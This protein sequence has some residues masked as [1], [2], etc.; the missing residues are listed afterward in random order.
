MLLPSNIDSN[1]NSMIFVDNEQI[2][3]LPSSLAIKI[4][5]EIFKYLE[6]LD[7][8]QAKLVC[9][10]WKK[11][12]N[13]VHFIEKYNIKLKT[14]A[15]VKQ[16]AGNL[17][18]PKKL[19]KKQ[20]FFLIIVRLSKDYIK[21]NVAAANALMILK[22]TKF[23]FVGSDFRGIQATGVRLA[24]TI[25]DKVNFSG[26]NLEGA[27][28]TGCSLEDAILD[29]AE[30]RD[31]QFGQLPYLNHQDDV[32]A[33][34]VSPDGNYLASIDRENFYVW[35]LE[36]FKAKK[37]TLKIKT[38]L[39][40]DTEQF[41]LQFFHNGQ[42]FLR[43]SSFEEKIE[44]W[45]TESLEMVN[46]LTIDNVTFISL[47][48]LTQD[49]KTLITISI[50]DDEEFSNEKTEICLWQINFNE[51][52]LPQIT[53]VKTKIIRGLA[54]K[55]SYAPK[56]SII[57]IHI[58]DCIEFYSLPNL[59]IKRDWTF[60]PLKGEEKYEVSDMIFTPQES[61]LMINI[62]TKTNVM[63]AEFKN[64]FKSK[65]YRWNMKNKKKG[66]YFLKKIV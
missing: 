37:Q 8:G 60:L 50:K 3:S 55:A 16:E 61:Q 17:S 31:I 9:R 40:S 34:T 62:F 4:G 63:P 19:K 66:N 52:S 57:A 49:E 25:L 58:E 29:G 39:Y 26:A 13:K 53:K 48:T 35:N 42:F 56:T 41:F 27:D 22:K 65:V 21:I 59:E 33:M 5:L 47:L 36:T 51:Q 64:K 10:K 11:L 7:R 30:L 23:S 14:S 45:R 38:D 15:E 1:I 54:K 46:E 12:I 43:S 32:L 2:P 18:K 44:I 6:L 24:R 20:H 28:F